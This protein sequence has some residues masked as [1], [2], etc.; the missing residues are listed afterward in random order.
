MLTGPG[1][2]GGPVGPGRPVG[3]GG[4]VGRGG[5]VGPGGLGWPGRPGSSG[6]GVLGPCSSPGALLSLGNACV[7][8]GGGKGATGRD[9]WLTRLLIWS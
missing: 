5:L 2:P 6:Y 8:V 9:S 1:G 3:P 7:C 4:P